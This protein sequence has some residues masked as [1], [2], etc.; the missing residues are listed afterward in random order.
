MNEILF[1]NGLNSTVQQKKLQR[2]FYNNENFHNNQN[3]SILLIVFYIYFSILK[4][5][6]L[7]S[8]L[9]NTFIKKIILHTPPAKI[10]N[11]K[12]TVYYTKQIIIFL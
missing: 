8:W 1:N 6:L 5:S 3:E 12:I 4:S 2:F 10:C 7:I 11:N 9:K